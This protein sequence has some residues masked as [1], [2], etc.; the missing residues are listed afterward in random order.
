MKPARYCAPGK[1]RAPVRSD[2]SL[3]KAS[4]IYYNL[5]QDSARLSS[6]VQKIKSTLLA[7]ETGARRSTRLYYQWAISSKTWPKSRG[8]GCNSSIAQPS[9][10]HDSANALYLIAS[11]S[12]SAAIAKL[13]LIFS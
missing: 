4:T 8:Q 1:A 6:F 13:A 2:K 10:L 12:H 9:Y 3:N 11:S 7:A 5:F